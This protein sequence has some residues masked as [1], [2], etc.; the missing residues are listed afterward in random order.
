MSSGSNF[1][2][3]FMKRNVRKVACSVCYL[4]L[5]AGMICYV[6]LGHVSRLGER[7]DVYRFL[8]GK[9]DGKR[10]LGRPKCGW[11]DN[12]EIDLQELGCGG[13]DLV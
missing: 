1:S 7:R 4:L 9:P 10:S 6:L 12:I 11:K 3:H 8:V 13:I 5:K 2:F